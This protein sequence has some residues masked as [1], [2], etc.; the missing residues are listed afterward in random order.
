MLR[1]DEELIVECDRSIEEIKRQA[2]EII[3]NL[4]PEEHKSTINQLFDLYDDSEDVLVRC[5]IV[6][7]LKNGCKVRQK[8]EQPKKFDERRRKTEIKIEALQKKLDGKAPQGRDLTGQKW[9]DTLAIATSHVPQD[10][11]QAKYWQDILLTQSKS[12]PYPVA[13][14]SNEDTKWGKNEQNRLNV[15]FNGLEKYIGKHVF[16]IYCDKRQLTLFQR[17]YDEQELKKASKN[18]H[19]GALL[20]LRSSRIA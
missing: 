3:D 20:V 1:S 5:A 15:R 16:Q 10:D 14:L 13:F 7:L 2:T 6:H 19:S 9:L 11:A 12:I 8:P 4:P 18:N 17:F